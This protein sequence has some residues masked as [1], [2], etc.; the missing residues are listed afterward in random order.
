VN[1][2][3]GLLGNLREAWWRPRWRAALVV[4]ALSDAVSFGLAVTGPFQ[5]A[6]DLV[7]A[8]ALFAILGFRWPLFVPLVTESIPG[9]ALFPAWI[10]FVGAMAAMEGKAPGDGKVVDAEPPKA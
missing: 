2:P 8:V 6:G 5:V 7:T 10:L 4:A 3:A 9:A 1:I